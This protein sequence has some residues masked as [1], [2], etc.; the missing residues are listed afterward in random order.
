[1]ISSMENSVGWVGGDLLW[2][3][4]GTEQSLSLHHLIPLISPHSL[5][6]WDILPQIHFLSGFAHAAGSGLAMADT[7]TNYL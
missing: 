4:V 7:E 5:C 2:C 1:M 6:V 3:A